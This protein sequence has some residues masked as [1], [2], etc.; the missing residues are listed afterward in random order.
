M[1]EPKREKCKDARCSR[2]YCRIITGHGI[3]RVICPHCNGTG[4]EP[5][6]DQA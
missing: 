4:E 6:D 5:K 2:G 1:S 3:V